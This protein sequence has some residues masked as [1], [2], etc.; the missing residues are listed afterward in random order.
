MW[1]DIETNQ[2]YLNFSEVADLAAGI[3]RNEQM[4]PI[5][6]GVFGGWGSGKTSLLGLIEA[7][8]DQDVLSKKVTLVKFDAWLY[9]GYDDAR[10]ALMEVIAEHL[11]EAAK[12]NAGILGKAKALAARI[13]YFR[14]IGI[15]ADVGA[16]AF[17]IP[18][19]GAL[20]KG[21]TA[22]GDIVQG[23]GTQQ[24]L[25]DAKAAVSD[26]ANKTSNLIQPAPERTPPKEISAFREEFSAVLDGLATTL[27]VVI[28]NLDR[29]LPVNAIHTLEAVRLFL[30]MPRT[31][32]VIAADEDMIRQSVRGYYKGVGDRHV[33]DYLDKFIQVPVRVP[34]LGVREVRAYMFMLYASVADCDPDKVKSLRDRLEK[35]LRESWKKAPIRVDEALA[36][37]GDNPGDDVRRGFQIAD[38]I[39]PVLSKYS[40][41][42]GNPRTVKR[43]LNVVRMRAEIAHNRQMTIDEALIAKLALFE[44]CTD[45][46]AVNVLYT[47]IN[48]A[49]DGKSAQI[50]KL[51]GLR[52]DPN[53]LAGESQ[54]IWD[55]SHSAFLQD[56]FG[57]EPL[58]ADCDLRPALYLSRETLPLRHSSGELSALAADAVEQLLK[59]QSQV[60]PA[61][62]RAAAAVPRDEQ[63]I[64][65]SVIISKLR[66]ETTWDSKPGGF[67]GALILAE[68]N[69][70]AASLLADFIRGLQLEKTPPWLSVVLKDASW[71]APNGNK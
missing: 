36:L 1:P 31:A 33:T 58:L 38:R 71:Y 14:L 29:C 59:T 52:D 8:L 13:N 32:F 68:A 5:S 64:V 19:F 48:E 34:R 40:T 7:A 65:M 17:G 45:S 61:A 43:L 26:V 15:A 37:L 30:F 39:A 70:D 57:L 11:L 6:L 4:L 42:G 50:A 18:T 67:D 56:W 54:R 53:K 35:D 2:D 28:D 62:T 63:P 47:L 9:Q 23:H 51:E 24:D 46:V 44:R 10:A 25:A 60:S 41:V 3:I 12:E 21:A 16:A 22:I 55:K 66:N 27:V 20:T 49:A 69:T